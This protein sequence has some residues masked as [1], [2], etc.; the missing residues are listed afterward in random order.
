M[1]L[2][3]TRFTDHFVQVPT[4]LRTSQS[5]APEPSERGVAAACHGCCVNAQKNHAY[6]QQGEGNA[7]PALS[8]PTNSAEIPENGRSAMYALGEEI[9]LGK[10]WHGRPSEDTIEYPQS[11]SVASRSSYGGAN[12][13]HFD[14]PYGPTG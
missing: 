4:H 14:P 7:N 2:H 10:A 11:E 9:L 8:T 12:Q 5:A 1:P 6:P 13:R 3:F